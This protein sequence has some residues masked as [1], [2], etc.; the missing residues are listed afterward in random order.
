MAK[1][2][3]VYHSGYGKTRIQAER[4]AAGLSS[5]QGVTVRVLTSEQA[6]ADMSPLSEADCIVFGCPTYMGGP[7]A[8]FKEFIDAAGQIWLKQG[9]RDKLAAGFTN[10]GSPAGDKQSTLTAL[11]LNA[12]Q[13]GMVWIGTGFNPHQVD[14][15]GRKATLNRLGF[16]LGAASQAPHGSTQPDEDDLLTAEAFGKRVAAAALRWTKGRT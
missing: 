13:H 3:L 14:H 4:V 16:F 12:M 2:A 11:M 7:S 15:N 6:I 8:K 9:W 1:V 5:V 10:S